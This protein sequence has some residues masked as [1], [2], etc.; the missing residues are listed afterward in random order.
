MAGSVAMVPM[1]RYL[2]AS[3]VGDVPGSTWDVKPVSG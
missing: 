1:C 2:Q 3:A